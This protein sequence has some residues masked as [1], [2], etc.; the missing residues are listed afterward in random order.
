[1]HIETV[2]FK[3]GKT[4]VIVYSFYRWRNWKLRRMVILLGLHGF[5]L[6]SK[7]EISIFLFLL[8]QLVKFFCF[9]ENSSINTNDSLYFPC[10]EIQISYD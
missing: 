8:L 4:F 9:L 3:S 1:M 5:L 7:P 10:E 6:I 2:M